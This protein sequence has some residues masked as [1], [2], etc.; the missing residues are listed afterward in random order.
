MEP[1]DIG[2]TTR[3]WGPAR[4]TRAPD[5]AMEPAD[6]RRDDAVRR[7]R[8]SPGPAAMEPADQRRDDV[9]AMLRRCPTAAAME[10]ADDRRDDRQR[11]LGSRLQRSSPQ[12]SP[13]IIGGTTARNI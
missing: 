3:R 7:L 13:P 1:A 5:A 4:T 6:Q 11:Q 9:S 12:W 10:P 8:P 2:G